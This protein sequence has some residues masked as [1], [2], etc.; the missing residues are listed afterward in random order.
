MYRPNSPSLIMRTLY[1]GAN[2]PPTK[3]SLASLTSRGRFVLSFRRSLAQ[4]VP[5]E[6]KMLFKRIKRGRMYMPT[7]CHL[8]FVFPP[9]PSLLFVHT[10]MFHSYLGHRVRGSRS[11]IRSS[12]NLTQFPASSVS[13][14]LSLSSLGLCLMEWSPFVTCPAA[15]GV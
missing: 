1:G 4:V 14:P 12:L 2:F 9:F 5:R 13:P 6:H 10:T 3:V 15:L 11:F 8:C 7:P